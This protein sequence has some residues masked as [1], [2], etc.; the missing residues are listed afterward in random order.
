MQLADFFAK[1]HEVLL[2]LNTGQVI[3]LYSTCVAMEV[4]PSATQ[5]PNSLQ[6]SLTK[7][8]G[9]TLLCRLNCSL[10]H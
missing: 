9:C 10:Y 7:Y 6:G 3:S 4:I 5:R 2:I 1:G 8:K